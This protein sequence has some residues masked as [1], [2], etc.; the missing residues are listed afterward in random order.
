M[1]TTGKTGTVT[2]RGD[3][4]LGTQHLGRASVG[5]IVGRKI[6]NYGPVVVTALLFAGS[7]AGL[8]TILAIGSKQPAEFWDRKDIALG[9]LAP[10]L[11]IPTFAGLL[12]VSS[13][14]CHWNEKTLK[15]LNDDN[16]LSRDVGDYHSV[17]QH[18]WYKEKDFTLAELRMHNA[19]M[20]IQ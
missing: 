5:K 12:I 14:R 3:S 17:F 8:A 7:I 20:G 1:L 15:M 18:S 10:F 9:M 19:I 16:S 4:P 2:E 13:W 11:G 6:F